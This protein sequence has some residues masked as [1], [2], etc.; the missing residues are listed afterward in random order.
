MD[1]SDSPR[2]TVCSRVAGSA[3]VAIPGERPARG[4]AAV[5]SWACVAVADDGAV[6]AAAVGAAVMVGPAT[7][8]RTAAPTRPRAAACGRARPGQAGRGQPA[9][10]GGDLEEDGAGQ[11]QPRP[12][13][14]D[15]QG[16]HGQG[17]VVAAGQGPRDR[18]PG[19]Q[20]VGDRGGPD[21]DQDGGDPGQDREDGGGGEQP[22]QAAAGGHC[23]TPSTDRVIR[24]WACA[25]DGQGV[26]ADDPQE[27]GVVGVGGGHGEGVAAGRP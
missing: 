2:V 18:L 13:R 22:D 25:G 8:S 10:A 21:G 11:E 17:A 4:A 14:D 23:S 15:G 19:G 24:A 6:A 16:L 20:P 5:T 7:K 27:R 9:Q 3:R 1:H 12:P 26:D